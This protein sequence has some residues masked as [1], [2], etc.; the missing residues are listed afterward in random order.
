MNTDTKQHNRGDGSIKNF[1]RMLRPILDEKELIG[2]RI[3]VAELAQICRNYRCR[4]PVNNRR[5]LE[6][7]EELDALGRGRTFIFDDLEISVY[8]EVDRATRRRSPEIEF[9]L[10][11]SLEQQ[12]LDELWLRQREHEA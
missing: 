5:A 10:A 8:L 7:A 4:L 11:V 9:Q 3:G 2:K 12:Y 6:L 1:L